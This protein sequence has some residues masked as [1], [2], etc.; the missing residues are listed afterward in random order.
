MNRYLA[1]KHAARIL[2]AGISEEMQSCQYRKLM[3]AWL[4]RGT[5]RGRISQKAAQDP[6]EVLCELMAK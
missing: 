3:N 5:Q 2:L 4:S 1:R 6:A